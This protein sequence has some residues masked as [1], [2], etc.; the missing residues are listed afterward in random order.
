MNDKINKPSLFKRI[1]KLSLKVV[2]VFIIT[3]ILSVIFFKFVPV[4]YTPL[5]F[6]KS[7]ASVFSEKFV[8]INHDWVPLEKISKSMQRAVIK[9]EDYKFYQHN[10]FDFEAIQKAIEYN[11]THKRKI[12]AS[13][14]SQ[15]TAKNVF[16]WPSRSWIRKGLEVYFTVLIEFFWSKER[17]IEVYLNV[18]EVGPGIYGV[19]AGA[20]KFFKKPAKKLNSHE[21]SLIAAVLPNPI[22]FKVD[23]PSRYV[24]RRQRKILGTKIATQ[25]APEVEKT[26]ITEFFDIKFDQEDESDKGNNA[27]S[28]KNNTEA[29]TSE[30]VNENPTTNENSSEASATVE[31]LSQ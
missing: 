27:N 20:Q 7:T 16:L 19:E 1:M 2:L 15:Q 13:T 26:T 8:G 11:K 10:G 18:I 5:M 12:G 4:P 9:A 22:K 6:W 23:K 14:I 29:T 24:L 21:A 25:K 28:E 17:I 3:S 31:A 30:T